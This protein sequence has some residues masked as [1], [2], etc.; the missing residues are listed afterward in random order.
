MRLIDAEKLLDEV[1]CLPKVTLDA[2]E[3]LIQQAPT[4]AP[5][6][7]PPTVEYIWRTK[8][9]APPQA[10]ADETEDSTC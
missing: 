8:A 4:V 9:P 7:E 5:A 1:S 2:V 6:G 10:T 3:A